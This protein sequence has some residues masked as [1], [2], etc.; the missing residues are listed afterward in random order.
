MLPLRTLIGFQALKVSIIKNI[1]NYYSSDFT[2]EIITFQTY[3]NYSIEYFYLAC[4]L[5]STILIFTRDIYE[6]KE[7]KIQK[8]NKNTCLKV[9]FIVF[10]LIFTKDIE[11]AI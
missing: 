1:A 6:I 2:R 10:T 9:F 5:T 8:I 11:N 4:F 7:E 3:H